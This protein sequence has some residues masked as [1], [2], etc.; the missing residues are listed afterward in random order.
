[1]FDLEQYEY[2]EDLN[3]GLTKYTPKK[4]LILDVACGQ[5][6]LGEYYRKK[7]N[8]VWGIDWSKDTIEVNN[9]RLDKYINEDITNF[10]KV[11]KSLGKRKFD[12][13]VFADVLEHIYDPIGT[14]KFYLD[15]LKPD[16]KIYISVPNFVVFNTR[17]Q[18]L[19][20]NFNYWLAGT[21]EK[22]HVRIFT[23]NNLKKLVKESGLQ[24][25]KLDITP[26]IARWVQ[27]MLRNRF[28][29]SYDKFDRQAIM[30]SKLYTLYNKYLYLPEYWICRLI[31]GL[32][33]YQ[34]I[35]VAS[36]KSKKP[37]KN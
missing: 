1:M 8:V 13:I 16:G 29:G 20:G 35:A 19:F 31:P 18:L 33:A 25:E 3:L 37:R 36:M 7:G 21:Q 28:T 30:K 32:L 17:L 34:Y 26:G 14:L 2:F 9:Q 24:L 11:R 23:Q 5:G 12:V 22:T 4:K 15:F 10:E 27:H 6:T